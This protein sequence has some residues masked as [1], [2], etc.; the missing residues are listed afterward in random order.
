MTTDE[1]PVAAASGVVPPV[2]APALS[3]EPAV[4]PAVPFP[5]AGVV[6]LAVLGWR[7]GGFDSGVPGVPEILPSGTPVRAGQ[8]DAVLAAAAASHVLVERR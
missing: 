5:A 3:S 2:P 8:V 6:T 1:V 4:P 7:I